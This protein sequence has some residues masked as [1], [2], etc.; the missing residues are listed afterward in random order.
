MVQAG[1]E[2]ESFATYTI[3][4]HYLTLDSSFQVLLFTISQMQGNVMEDCGLP[5]VRYLNV[6]LVKF[7]V[8][9]HV[10]TRF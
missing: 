8:N 7:H 5:S 3:A 1:E 6:F 4:I 9:C 10:W 2:K